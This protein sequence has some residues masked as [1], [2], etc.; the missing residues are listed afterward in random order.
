MDAKGYVKIA[1]E[2][3]SQAAAAGYSAWVGIT[4]FVGST[5]EPILMDHYMQE[6]IKGVKSA[7]WT[8][9]DIYVAAHSLGTVMAQDYIFNNTKT[10]IFKGQMMMGGSLARKYRQNNNATGLTE[11]HYPVPTLVL[12]GEKDGLYRI[13]RNAES[14]WHQV[15]NIDAKEKDRYPVVLLKGMSHVSFMD[16]TALSFN[17]KMYDLAP[18]VE[19]SAGY[20][21]VASNMVS[22]IAKLKG[23]HEV[24]K[25]ALGNFVNDADAF[26]A[27]FIEAMELEGSYNLKIPCYNSNLVNPDSP[28]ECMRGSPWASKMQIVMGGSTADEDVD[29]FT[30]D[31][32]HRVYVTTPHHLPQVNNTCPEG[33]P[34]PCTLEGLTV[35]ENYY[36]RLSEL[37]TG[38]YEQAAVEQKAKMLSR[39]CVQWHA[40]HVNA[41]FDDLDENKVRCQEIN[42]VALQWGLDHVSKEALDRYNA[43]GKKLVIGEDLGPYNDGPQW[44]W[45]YLHYTDNKDKTETLITSPNMRT[46]IDYWEIQ[47]GGFHYC[48]LLS[49]YRVLEWIHVDGLQDHDGLKS[50]MD[51]E[52]E[53]NTLFLQK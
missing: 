32:F 9:D 12:A 26:F 40:G 47:V 4:N 36:H 52:S 5:P 42:K 27:P 10:S 37:D 13:S 6:T 21:L 11:W 48:K 44:I 17:I 34:K 51:K 16:K 19:E 53:D 30:F 41:S 33:G 35:T 50:M 45:E 43:K 24:A 7:G 22:F 3:Q 14:Y 25:A 38:F 31:N 8:G 23:E 49:P 28:K 1:T 18:E 39:Q 2:F 20:K 29:M 46:K 15:K